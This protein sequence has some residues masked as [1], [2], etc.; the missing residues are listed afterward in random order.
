MINFNFIFQIISILNS[1]LRE[2]NSNDGSEVQIIEFLNNSIDNQKNN[3][4]KY[5]WTQIE[6]NLQDLIKVNNNQYAIFFLI[7][8][9]FS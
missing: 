5:F 7:N 3:I 4:Q 6:T 2:N 9:I 8:M 1:Y